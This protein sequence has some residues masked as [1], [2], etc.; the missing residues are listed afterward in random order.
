MAKVTETRSYHAHHV[1]RCYKAAEAALPGAGFKI[2][3][4]RPIGWLIMA[5]RE[6]SEGLIEANVAARPGAGATVTLT[7]SGESSSEA[8]LSELVRKIFGELESSLGAAS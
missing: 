6:G 2:W 5:R 7:L 1:D 4:T 3:K 8:A